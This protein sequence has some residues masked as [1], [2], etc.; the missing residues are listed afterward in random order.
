MSRSHKKANSQYQ[1]CSVIIPCRNEKG[2]IENAV[3]RI[4]NFCD[5][6]EIIFV[7]GHSQDDT[8]EEIKRIRSKYSQKNIKVLQQDGYGKADA[9]YKGFDNS[10]GEVLMILD[11]D[12]AVPPEQL[13]K[14]WYLISS[15]KGEFINGTRLVYPMEI[16]A[17]RFLNLI[18]NQLFS[19][20]SF[21]SGT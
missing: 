3:L 17:M 16:D 19:K 5:D 10:S 11:A 15:G 12:L 4:P 8:Y 6:L 9:V 2:N 7:E 13:D 14:F 1:S 18:A 21:G 20:K